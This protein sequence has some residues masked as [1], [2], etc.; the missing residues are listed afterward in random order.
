MVDIFF[1]DNDISDTEKYQKR[2]SKRV[3]SL[4]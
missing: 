2:N 4:M 1:I 3:G